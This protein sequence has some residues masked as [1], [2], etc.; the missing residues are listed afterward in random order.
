MISNAF[1]DVPEPGD[2]PGLTSLEICLNR[3]RLVEAGEVG[4]EKS[5]NGRVCVAL[6]RRGSPDIALGSSLRRCM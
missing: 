3:R 1:R 6:T 4:T 5:Q 2:L